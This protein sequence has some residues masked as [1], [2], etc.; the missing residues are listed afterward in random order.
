MTNKYQVGAFINRKAEIDDLLAKIK[1]HLDNNF[2]VILETIDWNDVSNL[3]FIEGMLREV[4]S[5][6]EEEE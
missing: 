3:G 1:A 5:F 4:V 2:N 6:L